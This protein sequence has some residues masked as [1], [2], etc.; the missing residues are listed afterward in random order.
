MSCLSGDVRQQY[1]RYLYEGLAPLKRK[2][3]SCWLDPNGWKL[4]DGEISLL[5]SC[6]FLP[7][8]VL[9]TLHFAL[10]RSIAGAVGVS[11]EVPIMPLGWVKK[12]REYLGRYNFAAL[13]IFMGGYGAAVL[14]ELLRV[15][16]PVAI[17]FGGPDAI[18]ADY[19]RWYRK[20]LLQLW[21]RADICIFVSNFLKQEAIKRG[22]PAYKSVVLYHGV[23]MLAEPVE[24]RDRDFIRFIC[25]AR[26]VPWKGHEYLIRAFSLA[27]QTVKN[28]RLSL[29]GGSGSLGIKLKELTISLGVGDSVDFLGPMRWES[30]QK[31]LCNSN[32]YVQPSIKTEDGKEEGLGC[33]VLEAQGV[34]LP[35]IVFSS[36][37]LVETVVDGKTGIVV[38]VRN[39][40]AMAEAM[41][42]LA[43]NADM[44]SKM[45]R[46]AH[47]WVKDRFELNKQN[48]EWRKMAQK[49]MSIGHRHGYGVG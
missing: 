46:A 29:V 14:P 27:K 47:Q 15:D 10:Y 38:P 23:P 44:R 25:I 22:C 48:A 2:L 16:L 41:L 3:I 7:W 49:L 31:E 13:L 36:G 35:A 24:N 17:M 37:G 34:G 11:M 9:N 12:F 18:I 45:G 1:I 32:V 20:K 33:A 30:V 42:L 6:D 19:N 5:L 39:I 26:F 4:A 21:K 40:S 43:K 28:I 8:K